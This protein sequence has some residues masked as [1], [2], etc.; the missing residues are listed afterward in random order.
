[1]ELDYKEFPMNKKL[2]IPAIIM[3]GASCIFSATV[4][5]E[6]DYN[7]R[8]S[9]NGLALTIAAN[10]AQNNRGINLTANTPKTMNLAAY[11][12]RARAVGV[13][14]AGRAAGYHAGG[15]RYGGYGAGVS[16]GVS[17]GGARGYGAAV[18]GRGAYG[19]AGHGAHGYHHGARGV[20]HRGGAHRR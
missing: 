8:V 7:A 6:G 19:A 11:A 5:A 13:H 16:G 12:G 1:M 10:I 9:D 14:G 20:G 15:Y 2:I 17:V 4:L 18:G 3:G